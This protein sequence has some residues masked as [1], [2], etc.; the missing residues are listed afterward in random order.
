[1]EREGILTPSPKIVRAPDLL[2]KVVSRAF[3]SPGLCVCV[4]AEPDNWMYRGG[5]QSIHGPY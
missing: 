3:S 4:G 1:M 5:L 2:P